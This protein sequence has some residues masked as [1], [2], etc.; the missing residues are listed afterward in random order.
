[1]HVLQPRLGFILGRDQSGG[2]ILSRGE[3]ALWAIW[4][5]FHPNVIKTGTSFFLQAGII[6]M[7]NDQGMVEGIPKLWHHGQ[8]AFGSFLIIRP[9]GNVVS[10]EMAWGKLLKVARDVSQALS[11]LSVHKVSYL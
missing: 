7:L 11:M 8:A 9:Y 3:Q 1:M 6:G 10:S 4:S 2:S 5:M